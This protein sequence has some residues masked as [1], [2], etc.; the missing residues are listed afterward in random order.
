MISVLIQFIL[1]YFFPKYGL[2]TASPLQILPIIEWL[3]NWP[4][5]KQLLDTF[6]T[7]QHHSLV[8]MNPTFRLSP[9]KPKSPKSAFV[10]TH[11]Q[12][13][14]TNASTMHSFRNWGSQ[15]AADAHAPTGQWCSLQRIP[16]EPIH[17]HGWRHEAGKEQEA[18]LEGRRPARAWFARRKSFE[19]ISGKNRVIRCTVNR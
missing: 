15:L 5:V 19:K 14:H 13:P 16:A 10:N 1:D 3:H 7:Q 11:T 18:P 9:P 12:P 6:S 8:Q 4:S 17:G 2:L